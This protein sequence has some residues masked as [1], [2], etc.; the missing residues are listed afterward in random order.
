MSR[1]KTTQ[2]NSKKISIDKQYERLYKRC[3]SGGFVKKRVQANSEAEARSICT[4]EQVKIN[5]AQYD[6]RLVACFEM[7]EGITVFDKYYVVFYAK[8]I[9]DIMA[10][11]GCMAED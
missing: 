2:A 4:T 6:D 11:S 5:Q 10:S 8:E 7:T 1:Q 9:W 3:K